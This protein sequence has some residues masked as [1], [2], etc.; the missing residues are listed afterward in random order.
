MIVHNHYHFDD[1]FPD[2]RLQTKLWK[3]S[4]GYSSKVHNWDLRVL[5]I[6]CWIKPSIEYR[7]SR[8]YHNF[9]V[10]IF[11]LLSIGENIVLMFQCIKLFPRNNTAYTSSVVRNKLSNN[12]TNVRY[13]RSFW[14]SKLCENIR[15][16]DI[17]P[18]MRQIR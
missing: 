16:Y 1:T 9:F 12:S 8:H 5:I 6:G 4:I 14:L 7:I 11:S 18:C 3:H 15:F 2:V 17:P 13:L 10:Q